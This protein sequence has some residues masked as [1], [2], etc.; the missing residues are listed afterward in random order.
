MLQ[1]ADGTGVSV[2][3][4]RAAF[5]MIAASGLTCAPKGPTCRRRPESLGS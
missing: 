2:D 3:T 1:A 4:L 5:A